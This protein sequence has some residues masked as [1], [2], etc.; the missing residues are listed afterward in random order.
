MERY[1]TY[2]SVRRVASERERERKNKTSEREL[3]PEVSP[4]L[5]TRENEW[6]ELR[7]QVA[8]TNHHIQQSEG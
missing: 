3:A 8:L 1:G 5:K 2:G 4:Q 7:Q 6:Q